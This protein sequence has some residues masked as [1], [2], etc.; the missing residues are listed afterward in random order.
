MKRKLSNL[1]NTR[2]LV[3]M[4]V[5]IAI[6]I[7]LARFLSIQTE[8][9]RISFET[10]PIGLAGI[11]L[12]PAAGALV[13][14]VSDILGTIISGYGV[15]FPP[16]SL[17]PVA[18][19]VVCGLCTKYLFHQGIGATRDT[20]KVAFTAIVAGCL[21]SF[22]FGL[23]GVTLYQMVVVGRTDA[24]NVLIAAN[25]LERLATKPLT[26]VACAAVMAVVNRAVYRPVVCRMLSSAR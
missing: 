3:M 14:L 8:T 12:G 10:I 21:N 24:F 7:I 20:W 17:G 11:W 22:V 13:A 25:L 4:G 6:E 1:F 2:N 26:I 23:V 5:L 9:L 18:F 15:Y 16:L 19:A